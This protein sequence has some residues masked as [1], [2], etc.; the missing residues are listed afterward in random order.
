MIDIHCHILPGVDDGA[1]SINES[2]EMAKIA[3]SEGITSIIATPHHRNGKYENT[4]HAILSKV[5]ELNEVLKQ[6]SLSLQIL[7]GQEP[8]IYGEML[9]CYQNGELLTLNNTYKYLFIEFPSNHV[10]RYTDQLLYDIQMEGLIPIIVH[11]ERNQE[12]I[13]NPDILYQLVKKGAL[14]Q[15]TAS[16]MVGYFGKKISKFTNQLIGANL[17]HFISS[18]A[19]NVSNRRFMFSESLDLV[20]K[21]YGT[22]M[23]YFFIEN[24]E[25][26]VKGNAIYKE[27]PQKVKVKKFL[28]I[29]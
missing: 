22:D 5:D 28:G 14:T 9:E 21:Q 7:P 17:A 27:I 24:A 4:K 19:H 15:I 29:F 12:I 3:I 13:E 23:V 11:P 2:I 6:Q 8:R 25:L 18:D 1:Q 10:P 20:E 26:L 16:S